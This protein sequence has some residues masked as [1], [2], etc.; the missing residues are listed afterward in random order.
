M[1]RLF[2]RLNISKDAIDEQNLIT[3][4]YNLFKFFKEYPI[5]L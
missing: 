3:D 4:T 1:E 5:I 2:K